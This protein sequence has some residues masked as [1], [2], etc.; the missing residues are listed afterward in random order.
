M[1]LGMVLGF[2]YVFV[3]AA[4]CYATALI[5]IRQAQPAQVAQA[6]FVL[7]SSVGR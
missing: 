1:I 2:T 6:S 7:E 3:I 4:G 5:A